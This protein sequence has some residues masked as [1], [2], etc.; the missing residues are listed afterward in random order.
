MGQNLVM[1]LMGVNGIHL[2]QTSLKQNLTD[3]EVQMSTINALVDKFNPDGVFALMDLTVEAEAVGLAL[4]F[5]ENESPAVAEHNIQTSEDIQRLKDAWQGPTGR[6]QLYVEVMKKM[7]ENL[8][9]LKGAYVVGPFTFAGE[10]M[11]VGEL[12]MNTIMQPDLVNEFLEFSVTVISDYANALFEAGADT[13][14]MLEPTAMMIAPE[15]FEEFSLAPFKKIVENVNQQPIILH[16]CGNTTHLI[17]LMGTS[18]AAGLSLDWQ[19]DMEAAIQRIPEDVFLIGNLDPVKVFLESTPEGVADA[20]QALKSTM[21]K[22]PNFILSSGCDLPI[23]TSD[24]NLSAF[25]TAA[26]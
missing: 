16:I 5:G 20:T 25:M 24:E 21:A 12:T 15:Q 8:S 7:S 3:A 9:I 11:G 1:P 6:M 10:L 22:Y 23:K 19:V 18:G 13:V 17:D 2:T 26:R 14:C 4:N